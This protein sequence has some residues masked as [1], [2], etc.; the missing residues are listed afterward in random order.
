MGIPKGY[1]GK[2]AIINLTEQKAQIQPTE[3]FFR[4]YGIDPR[5]W[6]GGDGVITKILWKDFPQP[7][8]PLDPENEII[9][10]TGPWT[11][12]A[13]PWGSRTMLGCL[14][15]ETGGFGSGSFGW[16]FPPVMK[17]AGFDIVIIRGKA[18]KP[19]YIFIDDQMI[20]FKEAAHLWG[21]E[22]GETV[23][24]VRAELGENYEG[25]IRVLSTAIA[26]EH[27]VPYAPPCADGTSCP[28]R[29]GAGAV[30]GSKNLKA[31]AVRGTGE[32]A[33]HNPTKLLDAA[34]R[35]CDIYLSDPGDQ[36]VAG[37]WS[38]HLFA[39]PRQCPGKRQPYKG[40]CTSRRLSAHEQCRLLELSGTLL[41]LAANQG[42]TLCWNEAT[43]GTHDLLLFRSGESETGQYECPH[44]LRAP[45]SGIGPRP[46]LVQS[47]L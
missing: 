15:P 4:E 5:L 41:S 3:I 22:T 32:L 40:E 6:L 21:K 23:K 2:V 34:Q 36:V 20:T 7:V 37:T 42:R 44:L 11:G 16:M 30:M 43:R 46:C 18:K 8:D 29:T 14:S 25:E 45:Y 12:T 35:A 31:L 17:Y 47:G 19:V 38:N 26:G 28:G 24:A 9:I 39:D 13:A 1:A 10:A 33:I 27:L